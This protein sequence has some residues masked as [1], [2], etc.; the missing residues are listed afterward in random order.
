MELSKTTA[1]SICP[2]TTKALGGGW[3]KLGGG[4]EWAEW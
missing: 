3:G 1:E 4:V 2:T